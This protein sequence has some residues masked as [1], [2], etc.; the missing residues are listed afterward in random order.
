M[1]AGIELWLERLEKEAERWALPL[2]DTNYL[3]EIERFWSRVG[4]ARQLSKEA[5]LIIQEYNAT[6]Y[7]ETRI[8]PSELPTG[9]TQLKTSYSLLQRVLLE[10]PFRS[11]KMEDAVQNTTA[12]LKDVMA[13]RGEEVGKSKSEAST[14]KFS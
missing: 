14:Y 10:T 11:S 8:P 1:E 3:S 6:S 7:N 9:L 12:V 5:N 2:E 13:R 4:K